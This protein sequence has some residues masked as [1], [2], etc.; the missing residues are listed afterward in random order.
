VGAACFGGM[1]SAVTVRRFT[2][3][4]NGVF[5]HFPHGA[6]CSNTVETKW[7]K[8]NGSGVETKWLRAGGCPSNGAPPGAATGTSALTRAR[9]LRCGLC[10]A[11]T[12]ATPG[13]CTAMSSAGGWPATPTFA[14]QC[15]RSLLS[16]SRAGAR[17]HWSMYLRRCCKRGNGLAEAYGTAVQVF[18][19][20][21][22]N[23][24]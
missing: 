2:V 11:R 3:Y 13:R 17:M 23:W 24:C 20:W 14:H 4:S 18:H 7:L 21:E 10:T 15:R 8:R 12:R 5:A 22:G 9:C 19:H 6:L 1:Q 16:R